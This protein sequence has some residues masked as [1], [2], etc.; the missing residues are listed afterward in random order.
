LIGHRMISRNENRSTAH[1]II[2]SNKFSLRISIFN[3]VEGENTR[4][5]V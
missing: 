3:E 5:E 1:E 2:F 4:D